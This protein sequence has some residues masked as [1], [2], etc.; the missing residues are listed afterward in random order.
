MGSARTW[1]APQVLGA[2]ELARQVLTALWSARAVRPV[3]IPGRVGAGFRAGHH[4]AADPPRGARTWADY[5]AARCGLGVGPVIRLPSTGS[6][7]RIRRR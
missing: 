1:A 4:L 7:V 6:R 3:R 5:L 2:A